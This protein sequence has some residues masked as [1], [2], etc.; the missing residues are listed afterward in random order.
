MKPTS[1]RPL[2]NQRDLLVVMLLATAAPAAV[3][4]DL[5]RFVVLQPANDG[6]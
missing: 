4:L 6:G 5:T 3:A 2:L 1:L